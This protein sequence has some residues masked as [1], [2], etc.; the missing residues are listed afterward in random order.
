M[1]AKNFESV[2]GRLRCS[3]REQKTPRRVTS[4]EA[5]NYEQLSVECVSKGERYNFTIIA[6]RTYNEVHGTEHEELDTTRTYGMQGHSTT[7]EFRPSEERRV[8]EHRQADYRTSTLWYMYT[9]NAK[10]ISKTIQQIKLRL[11]TEKLSA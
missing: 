2:W 11:Y 6:V 1:H 7:R 3:G 10:Q 5:W 4:P 9:C 8:E